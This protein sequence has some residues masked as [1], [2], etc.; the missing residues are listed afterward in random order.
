MERK[1]TAG[2]SGKQVS[3]IPVGSE[4][5]GSTK[6]SRETVIRFEQVLA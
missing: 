2:R 6:A 5:S 3:S 1:Q 4:D